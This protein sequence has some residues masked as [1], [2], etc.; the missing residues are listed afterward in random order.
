MNYYEPTPSRNG[1]NI[2]AIGV[3]PSGELVRYDSSRRDFVP[4]LGGR[5]LAHLAFSHDGG[6]MAYVAY[7]EGTLWRA[8]SDG[9]EPLQL[10]FPPL[11]VGSPRWSADGKLIAFHAVQ[12][13]QSWKNFV[14]SSGGGN[15]EPF[16]PD[17]SSQ[18]SPDWVPGRDALT[19]S[20]EYQGQSPA[21]HLFDRASGRSEKIPGTEGL[22]ALISSPDGRY[23][24]ATDAATDQL[25]LVDLRSGRRTP[26]AGPMSWATWS[27]DSQYIY[28]VRWGIN[29]ILRVHV[30]DGRE[31][32]VLEV[33]FRVAPWP[34]TVAPD[35]SLILLREHGRYDVYSLSL[36]PL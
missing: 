4:F 11:Q 2:L 30:P 17:P 28:F 9:T 3:Q 21:V 19:Y 26:I 7:P 36:S 24:S 25:L 6:W 34:F 35:G 20:R 14:I 12:P 8:R 22:C 16:P 29:A 18:S 27:P 5:S 32:K 1:K 10:T 15:P 13:G 23:T 31:E 33:P